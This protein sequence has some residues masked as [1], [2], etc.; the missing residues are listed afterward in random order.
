MDK[1]HYLKTGLSIILVFI[2]IKML[3]S[4]VI[5]ISTAIFLIAIL[6]ILSIAIGA[7]MLR[8]KRN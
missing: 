8:N 4:N 2:G 5:H 3:I 6:L 1:F 7:S